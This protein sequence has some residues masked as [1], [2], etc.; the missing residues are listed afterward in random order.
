MK[1]LR[2]GRPRDSPKVTKGIWKNSETKLRLL[3]SHSW[4]L[5][6]QPPGSFTAIW[7]LVEGKN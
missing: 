1:K 5:L 3:N 2:L 4:S 6:L 7:G